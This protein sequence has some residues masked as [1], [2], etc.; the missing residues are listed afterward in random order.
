MSTPSTAAISSAC[1]IAALELHDHHGGGVDRR[2][3]LCGRQR[4]VL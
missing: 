2:I 4:A 3:R 1:S